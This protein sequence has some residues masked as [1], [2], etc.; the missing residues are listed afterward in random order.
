MKKA[1]S[2]RRKSDKMTHTHRERERKTKKDRGERWGEILHSQT[3]WS[4]KEPTGFHV[5]H[6]NSCIPGTVGT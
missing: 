5:M 1:M 4:L 6:S 3:N 2:R